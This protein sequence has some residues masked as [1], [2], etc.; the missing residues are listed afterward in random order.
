MVCI[1]WQSNLQKILRISKKSLRVQQVMTIKKFRIQMLACSTRNEEWIFYDGN[2]VTRLVVPGQDCNSGMVA[3]N[4][5]PRMGACRRGHGDDDL[6]CGRRRRGFRWPAGG[7]KSWSSGARMAIWHMD[8]GDVGFGDRRGEEESDP[9]VRGLWSSHVNGGDMGSRTSKGKKKAI[10][11]C[12]D[13]E[14]G[15]GIP[16]LAGTALQRCWCGDREH[17]YRKTRGTKFRASLKTRSGFGIL[18]IIISD[19]IE[20][21]H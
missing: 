18:R 20:F 6:A 15:K 3:R 19:N 11:R 21:H 14:T 9:M 12:G 5:V 10:W 2:G 16:D 17:K 4:R 1:D 13:G 8:G 7:R